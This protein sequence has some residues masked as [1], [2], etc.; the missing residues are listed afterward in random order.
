MSDTTK[1]H[2]ALSITN[3]KSFI[4]ITLDNEC[5]LYHTWVTLFMVQ[6]RVHNLMHHIIPLM[7]EKAKAVVDALKVTS[8]GDTLS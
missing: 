7:E 3:V 4:P 5:G 8:S 2:P 1:F 6:A